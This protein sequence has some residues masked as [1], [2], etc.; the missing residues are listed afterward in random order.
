[1]SNPIITLLATEK[2]DGDNYAKWKSNMNILLVCED[3][4][5]VIVEE[6]P[7][8]PA[9]NATKAAREPYDRWIKANNKAKCFMLASMSDVLRK[10]HEEME[11]AYEIMEIQRLVNDGPLS[12]LKVGGLPVCE[13]CLEGKMTKRPFTAKGERATEPL[14]LI[15]S[16]TLRSDRWGEYLD[17]EFRDFLIE[18]GVVSQLTTPGTPQQNGIAERRNQT[19]LDIIRSMLSYS[20]LHTSF[21]DYALRTAAYILNRVPSKSIPKTPLELWCGQKPSLRHVRIWGCPAHVLKGKT[22]KLEPKSEVCM[23]VG[24][25]DGTKGD[26]FYSPEDQKI[27]P[28][29]TRVVEPLREKTTVPNQTPKAPRRSGR[30]SMLPDQYTGEAQIV[31][32]DDGKNDPSIFKDAIDDSDKEELQ[33]AM[34]L[35][36]ESMYSNSVWQLVDLPEGVKPIGCKW[37]YKSKR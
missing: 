23:F 32:A 18:E 34:K 3:Y 2:L 35:E 6:C 16:D 8:K 15:H 20:S 12:E 31:T 28:Q 33:A 30:V 37:I 13:S 7:P 24:Y 26:F 5:F 17:Q 21:W 27:S 10:K 9:A 14:Q 4:K 25:P 22:E 1:M 36:M 19:L 29:P 11:T